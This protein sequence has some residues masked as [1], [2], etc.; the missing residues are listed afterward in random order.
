MKAYLYIRFSSKKQELGDSIRR[1]EEAAK[2]WC[3]LNNVELS[4]LT[5]EDLGV[6]AFK[7]GGKRPALADLIETIRMGK[8]ERGSYVLFENTDRLTRRGY[9]HANELV[10]EIVNLGVKLVLVS[11][12]QVVEKSNIVNLAPMLPLLLD[13]DRAYAESERKSRLIRASRQIRR[14]N[15]S[16]TGKL[17]FWL[18]RKD[19][20]ILL[21]SEKADTVRLIVELK[22]SGKSNQSTARFLNDQNI[23]SAT[24]GKWNASAIR[25]VCSNH[26]IYGAKAYFITDSSRKMN[27][28]KVVE[29]KLPAIVTK[30]DF[31]AVQ[32]TQKHRGRRSTKTPFS[33]LLKCGKC[34]GGMVQRT[35]MYKEKKMIYRRCIASLEGRCDQ[36][37][38]IR[39][40]DLILSAA[41]KDMTYIDSVQQHVS[42]VG[43]IQKQIETLKETQDRLL[44]LGQVDALT[45]LYT[46]L[47]QLEQRLQQAKVED[48]AQEQKPIDFNYKNVF[49]IEDAG[50]QNAM[51]KR[52]LD[53]IEVH[54]LGLVDKKT[55]SKWRI[56][57]NQRNNHHQSFVVNQYHG[58]GNWEIVQETNTE[59]FKEELK[60]LTRGIDEL[61][62]WQDSEV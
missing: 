22:K 45:N 36:N 7:E 15:E 17:P 34:G 58:F 29:D 44:A 60:Q 61:E 26:A 9:D 21:D 49:D 14:D 4:D 62:D 25:M 59:K 38:L 11:T 40:P 30:A 52:V 33:L 1:Q 8:I 47:S 12:G 24:G 2:R 13:A 55:S 37:K 46:T 50:E 35:S 10:K 31:D 54:Y 42:M 43:E 28:D 32:T 41:L 18:I 3:H 51:L 56:K 20:K 39:E 16:L 48:E 19:G 57:V 27:L 23:K 5:F 6:S 53:S